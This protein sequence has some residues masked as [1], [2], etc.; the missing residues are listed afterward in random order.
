MIMQNKRILL[1]ITGGIAAYKIATLIRYFIKSGAEV[2]CIMTPAS[3]DFISPLTIATLSKNP[4]YQS[5]WDAKTGEWS[6]H[7]A[8][9]LWADVLVIAPC[10]ANSLAK[11]AIGLSDNLLVTT[12][13]SAKCPVFIAPAM[14]LDMYQHSTTKRNLQTLKKDGNFI[15]PAQSGELAS[16]LSGEGRMM[17]PEDIFKAI[18]SFLVADSALDFANKKVIVTAGP[19]Y[20]LI[21]PVRFIGNHSSGKMGVEI[22]LELARR[23]ADVILVLGPSNLNPKHANLKCVS[24]QSAEEMFS[25][26]KK[27]WKSQ[28][29]GV[30]SAAVADYKPKKV[31]NEKIKKSDANL[32]IELIKNPDI[33]LWAGENK[34]NQILVGFALETENEESNAKAKLQKKNLDAVVLNSLKNDGAGFG[35]D[36]N[37]ITIFDKD[38]KSIDFQLKSKTEVA[39]DIVNFLLKMKN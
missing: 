3:V 37:K 10:T 30:F 1:G 39:K 9:A 26:V 19:T 31:A 18:E 38:N 34:K 32:T 2:K 22:A 27:N 28:N 4:V 33:L 11:L 7:V 17:E 25:V 23:G 15:L 13:L 21:D 5:F 35:G 6:N 36:T 29:I 8:L 16:G 12:Y 20:E 24:V 14:D